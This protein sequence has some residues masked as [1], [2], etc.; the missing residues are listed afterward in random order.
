MPAEWEKHI[1]TWVTYP[2]E[3]TTFF[4]Y[5]EQ[6]R[7]IFV[8][9]VKII[10]EGETV[11]INVND[12]QM[13]KDLQNRLKKFD[14]NLKNTVIHIFPT[15]D[16]WCRDYGAIFV[17]KTNNKL[18]ATDW[19]F[20]AWG[21]KYPYELDNQIAKKMAE[22]LNVEYLKVDM[23]LEGGSI[24]T[25]GDGIFLTTESC[26][27]NPN[28]NP[29]KTKEEIEEYLSKYLGAEKVLWL[30]EGIVGDD[31]DGHIDD[32]TRFVG[33]NKIITA[34]ETNPDDE[35]YQILKENFERLKSFKNKE[36]KPF[37]IITLPM[38][39]P[40]YYKGERLPASYANFYISSSAVIVPIYNCPQDQE[41]LDVLQ[42]VFKD[43]KVIGLD[44]NPIIV[45]L[46]AF[47]CLTQ[48]IPE[49]EI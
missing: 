16:S 46:G 6:A 20:N 44:A 18:V 8:Q 31:T 34:L 25:N 41:A 22:Y 17:K 26:L 14:V 49:G 37:E 7:D 3:K 5:L 39:E 47:H 33:K 40:R 15:N 30:K 29:D 2:H 9:M 38:P 45:G 32:I 13:K 43:R 19:E 1:G 23:V 28:R 24:D 21:G 12:N 4:E 48:Q 27:L 36:G 10:S 11:H 35:N 42:S